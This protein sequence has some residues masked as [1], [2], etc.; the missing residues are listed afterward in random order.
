MR[1]LLDT[2]ILLWWLG[3]SVALSAEARSLIADPANNVFISAATI[4]EIRIKQRL[5]KLDAPDNL[6]AWVRAEEFEW[7]PVSVE[8]ADATMQLPMLHRDPFD[9]MLVAQAKFLDLTLLTADPTVASYGAN[10]RQV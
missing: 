8:H 5:G 6:L 4:W 10:V 2:H 3:D 7:V 1:L 9:R